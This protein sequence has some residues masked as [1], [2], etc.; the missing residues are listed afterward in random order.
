MTQ[1][2]NLQSLLQAVANGKISP[3]LALESL[4]NLAYESVGEFAKIDHHRHLR[5]GF[6]EV[7]WGLGKTPDQIA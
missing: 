3:D 7:I 6:P 5:T 2:E 4:K 1:P